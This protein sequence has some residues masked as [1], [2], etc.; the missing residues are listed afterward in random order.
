MNKKFF[1][2]FENI[3]NLLKKRKKKS[4]IKTQSNLKYKNKIP[5]LSKYG[6]N[7]TKYARKGKFDPCYGRDNELLQLMEILVRRLKGNPVLIGDP[8]VGKTAII[9]HFAN[10]LVANLVPFILQG[11]SIISLDLAR[12]VAGSRFRGQFESRLQRIIKEVLHNPHIIVFIDEI[13]TL[14]GAG[15][16][17][18]ASGSMDAANILKPVLSRGGFQ[19]IGASTPK[20]YE[21][22]EKDPALGRRFQPIY[23]KEPSNEDT[24]KILYNLRPTF[25]AYHNVTIL[26]IALKLTID[27][28]AR[29]IADRY[30]PDKAIDIIDTAS[31][32]EV[33]RKTDITKNSYIYAIING[34]LKNLSKF[35]LEAFRKGAIA[36]QFVFQEIEY[37]YQQF[38]VKWLNNPLKINQNYLKNLSPISEKFFDK[39][40]LIIFQHI[41]ELLF[42]NFNNHINYI[43]SSEILEKVNNLKILDNAIQASKKK[44]PKL[45]AYRI[46]LY[47]YNMKNQTL[48]TNRLLKKRFL[49]TIYLYKLKELLIQCNYSVN[50]KYDTRKSDFKKLSKQF[51][52]GHHKYAIYKKCINSIKPLIKKNLINILKDSNKLHLSSITK[53][54][55]SNLLGSISINIDSKQLFNKYLKVKINSNLILQTVSEV[56]KIP[57]NNI[58]KEEALNLLSLESTLHQRVIGQ[59]EAIS[60]IAK[61]IRRSKLGLQNPNRPIASFLFCGP[62]GVGKT[63]IVKALAYTIFGSEKHILRFDMS[64]FM[65]KHSISRLIGSPPG[66]IGYN[67]GGQLTDGVRRNPYSIV[68]FDEAEKAHPDVLNILLQILEDG[69]LSDTQKRTISFKNTIIILTSNAAAFEIQKLVKNEKKDHKIDIKKESIIS[70]KISSNLSADKSLISTS[71]LVNKN[72][73]GFSEFLKAPIKESYLDDLKIHFTNQNIHKKKRH[74]NVDNINTI[75]IDEIENSNRLLKNTVIQKLSTIF[76]PEFLNRFDDI[77]T[78]RP[79]TLEELN[80]IC[81]IMIKYLV[82]RIKQSL[83]ITLL[84]DDNVKKKLSQDAYIPAFGARPLRRLITKSIEDKISEIILDSTHQEKKNPT[85]IKFELN[86]NKEI[87]IKLL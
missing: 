27:L 85:K 29:Y 22:I 34:T 69:R 66:Y 56:T 80:K 63:E 40:Q 77:I 12:I 44:F 70:N 54:S 19:C 8:G 3:N 86:I 32:K 1:S 42:S 83:N 78:F 72:Y 41:E 9:E 51:I 17:D 37:A 67:E 6:F 39:I 2:F 15:S 25:E 58:S 48:I 5:T 82:D 55:L 33:I 23:V 50:Y 79:L 49:F 59:E 4:K 26:P 30:F 45:S 57:M 43:K 61:A 18:G 47:L 65:E 35:R 81:H 38:L 28:T 24:I 13:H 87:I 71:L 60:A 76:L 53:K 74:D 64:E 11:R 10:Q 46:S 52:Q 68:L 20:E 14:S 7:F 62:T 21:R 75:K 84:I 31:A 73:Y 16:T 36:S